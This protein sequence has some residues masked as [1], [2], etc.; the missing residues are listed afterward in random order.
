MD[1]NQGSILVITL[2][3]LVAVLG[4]M[5]AGTTWYLTYSNEAN[6]LDSM[7]TSRHLARSGL[8]YHCGAPD[9]INTPISYPDGEF[10]LQ[11]IQE[12]SN[13]KTVRCVARSAGNPRHV[14]TCSMVGTYQLT[15]TTWK[16]VDTRVEG[17]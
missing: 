8:A 16:L 17:D 10:E 2:I 1:N 3:V 7:L 6:T 13:G 15:N 9:E 12:T 4:L 14:A 11:V 5:L